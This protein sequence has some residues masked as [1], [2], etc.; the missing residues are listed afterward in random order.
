MAQ[1][2]TLVF[3]EH[4]DPIVAAGIRALFEDDPRFLVAPSNAQYCYDNTLTGVVIAD[5]ATG[6]GLLEARGTQRLNLRL[7]ILTSLDGE[8]EIREAMNA[9]ADGYI[10]HG[11]SADEL[12]YATAKV[13]L[14]ARYIPPPIADRLVDSLT[15]SSL[16]VR[17]SEVLH[18]L[19]SGMCNKAVAR[20]LAIS[21]GTVK[22][23]VR[24]LLSKLS[25]TS[26]L[27]AVYNAQARGLVPPPERR[28]EEHPRPG[29]TMLARTEP[30]R[31]AV[32]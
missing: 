17:E 29:P 9:G 24:S 13:A 32:S 8:M 27:Q 23:H 20:E 26:R 18:L 6:L 21:T 16:T 1:Q 28:A 15:H 11:C 2:R 19:A 5:H 7:L 3:I 12:G 10:L 22:S 25:A 14:G 30:M 4:A 31:V